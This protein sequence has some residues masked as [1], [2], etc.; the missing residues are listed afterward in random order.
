MKDGRRIARVL[1]S[2]FVRTWLAGSLVCHESSCICVQV[3]IQKIPVSRPTPAVPASK[4]GNRAPKQRKQ[5]A[6]AGG[7]TVMAALFCFMFFWSP[8]TPSFR[9]AG[10]SGATLPAADQAMQVHGRILQSGKA[11]TTF[12]SCRL[13]SGR[14]KVECAIQVRCVAMARLPGPRKELSVY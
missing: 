2:F 6:I 4:A 5:Q 9:L 12:F 3:A 13:R 7:T 14:C 11:L 8:L 1:L 10:Q